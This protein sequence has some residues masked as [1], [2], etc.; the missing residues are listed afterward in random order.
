MSLSNS[1]WQE[2]EN[3][4]WCYHTS[5]N[6]EEPQQD[7]N[8]S[9]EHEKRVKVKTDTLKEINLRTYEDPHPT[10]VNAAVVRDDERAYIHLFNNYKGV[11]SWSFKEMSSLD[12]KVA[13]HHIAVKSGACPIMQAQMHF[14]PELVPVIETKVYKG[15]EADIIRKVKY[16]I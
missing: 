6:N 16:P 4:S 1:N 11:F 2:L 14:S 5:F 8:A 15:I 3:V 10:Y 12:M 13:V 9:S 7:E